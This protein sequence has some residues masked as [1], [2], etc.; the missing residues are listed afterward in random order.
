MFSQAPQSPT[1]AFTPK[2]MFDTHNP[3]PCALC[4][5]KS[6]LNAIIDLALC[7]VLS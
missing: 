7:L 6:N 2:A 5:F 4:P 1:I 3:Q